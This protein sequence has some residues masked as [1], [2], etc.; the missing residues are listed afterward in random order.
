MDI[1]RVT[2][3]E[4]NL[5]KWTENKYINR[6]VTTKKQGFNIAVLTSILNKTDINKDAV[7]F[8]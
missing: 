3:S 6:D 1:T 7:T 5:K 2:E 8:L 4:T